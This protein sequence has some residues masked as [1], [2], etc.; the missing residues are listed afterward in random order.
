MVVGM[1]A[2]P[3]FMF[4]TEAP[5]E[6]L[7]LVRIERRLATAPRRRPGAKEGV[8]VPPAAPAAPPPPLGMRD[9]D[10]DDDG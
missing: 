8:V 5:P 10:A 4:S 3:A 2:L 7:R 1:E 6:L 9:S